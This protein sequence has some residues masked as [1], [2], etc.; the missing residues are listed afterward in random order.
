MHIRVKRK[1]QYH[2]EPM[3][4]SLTNDLSPIA[5]HC[6]PDGDKVVTNCDN[7]QGYIQSYRFVTGRPEQHLP[8]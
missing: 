6:I 5:T 7:Y 1:L 8:D 3:C 4:M 2:A